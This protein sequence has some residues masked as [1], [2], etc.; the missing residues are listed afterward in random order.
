[1]ETSQLGLRVKDNMENIVGQFDE[2]EVYSNLIHLW[3]DIVEQLQM[4][5][6]N[7][8]SYK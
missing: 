5:S 8:T 1:M 4:F 2:K 7:N 6:A 3:N